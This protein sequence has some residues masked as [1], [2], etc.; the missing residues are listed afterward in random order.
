MGGGQ[1]DH[2]G[3]GYRVD[4]HGDGVRIFRVRIH[5]R[6]DRRAGSE[7]LDCVEI[8]AVEVLRGHLRRCVFQIRR[9]VFGGWDVVAGERAF[10]RRRGRV[11]RRFPE[12]RRQPVLL[13]REQTGTVRRPG[14]RFSE[15]P[16]ES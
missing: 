15:D 11:V 12:F 14:G 9:T 4:R 10:A 3:R 1:C 8:R 6:D 16:P 13:R 5:D 2:V 7:G